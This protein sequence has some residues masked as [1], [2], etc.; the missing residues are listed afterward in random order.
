MFF[1]SVVVVMV[2]VVVRLVVV[3]SVNKLMSVICMVKEAL[4]EQSPPTQ[5]SIS[6]VTLSLLLTQ[7]TRSV[8]FFPS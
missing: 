3:R 2:V 4:E 5:A 1:P 8:N 6:T 7:G